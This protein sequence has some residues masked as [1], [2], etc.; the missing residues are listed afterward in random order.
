VGLRVSGIG[1]YEDTLEIRFA[2][3]S[4]S[5]QFTVIR[6]IKAVIADASYT[7][8]LPQDPYVPRR[9]AER[10]EV[11]HFIRGQAP[12]PALAIAWRS[13]LGRYL[14]PRS[15]RETLSMPP[16][17]PDSGEDIVPTE[18][19]ALFPPSLVLKSHGKVFG[20]LLWL[21]EIATEYVNY[22]TPLMKAQLMLRYL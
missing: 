14:I 21:E 7:S 11:S 10:R 18:I 12:P 9:R 13:K 5:Q 6:K 15:V 22:S 16:N 19:R 3:V 1:N 17:R 20:I 2:R 4:T 8:L